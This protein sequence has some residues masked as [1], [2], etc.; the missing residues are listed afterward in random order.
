MKKV[1]LIVFVA[2]L[3]FGAFF[4]YRFYQ[5]ETER[6]DPLQIIP[7]NAIYWLETDKPI[8][9]WKTFS[10]SPFWT[11]MKTH[12]ELA[13]IGADAD[14]LDSLIHDNRTLFKLMGDRQFYMSAHMTK[15]DYDFLF[16][17]DL[18]Q[19][20]KLDLLLPIIKQTASEEDF[21]IREDD[22][23]GYTILDL[24][25]KAYKDH[26]YLAQVKN[27]LVCSYTDELVLNA[28]DQTE[29]ENFEIPSTY[30]LVADETDDDGLARVYVNYTQLDNYLRLYTSE[31]VD[32]L[33][34]MSKS[35]AYTGIDMELSEDDALFSGYT[36]LPD[37]VE[38][39]TKL[40]QKH[41][42]THF[43][44]EEVISART[45]YLQ[46]IGID[47]FK[48]FYKAV[49]QLRSTESE[50]TKEYLDVKNKV[51]KVLGLNLEKDLLAWIGEEIILAQN[52]P[53]YL[54]RNEEDLLVAIRADDIDFAT[55]KLLLLQKKI[56]R[57]T[58]ARFKKM[59]YKTYDIYYLDIKGFF[60]VFFGKAFSKLTKPYYTIV[61]D[62]V[63][64]SNSP[65]TLVSML[66]DYENGYV[67]A[68]SKEYQ[69]TMENLPKESTLLTYING[70]QTY[71]VLASK[72]KGSERADYAKNKPYL[73]FMRSIA[74]S[75]SAS[76][77]GF[78][79][80]IYLHFVEPEEALEPVPTDESDQL[81][82]KYL[83]DYSAQLKNLSE[84]ETFVL[85]E[86]NDG[87]FVK[88]F[89]GTDQVHIKAETRDGKFHGDFEEYYENGNMR[90]EGSYRKGRKTGRWKYYNEQ[91]E[92]TE[93]E[94][95]GL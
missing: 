34:A 68:K 71:P 50:S 73:S 4:G 67:L 53:S 10:E 47:D 18:E 28:I 95:E 7:T 48:D 2:L 87:D 33:D 14:Y 15:A 57:R 55:E 13:E 64:F 42:N 35:F 30:Q 24:Y 56:K 6:I 11:F 79:N 81:A 8:E 89:D 94:W 3:G 19:A 93:K 36:S 75:Y 66:E 86:V 54:H 45:A 59:Q 60:N 46:A 31:N 58:P 82:A 1:F 69:R 37:S 21:T 20:S 12:S 80:T 26:L 39:Y 49:L 62:Y 41:G 44:F 29:I 92:L 88:Y 74:V 43:E 85:N 78:E 52:K 16:L 27:F 91:G 63:I 17:V 51:E 40:L 70:P 23:K 61:D 38:L 25:D 5:T 32:L 83:Q 22:Y 72:I 65:K 84:A 9:N 76:G 90:S 77:D